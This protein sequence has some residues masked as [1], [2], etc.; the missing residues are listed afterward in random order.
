MNEDVLDYLF[1]WAQDTGYKY[2]REDFVK[3]I[4]SNDKV[5]NRAFEF[6]QSSK[7]PYKK[8]INS[9]ALL[10]GRTKPQG[11]Q[12]EPVAIEQTAKAEPTTTEPAKVEPQMTETVTAKVEE[13]VKESVVEEKPAIQVK[14]VEAPKEEVVKKEIPKEALNQNIIPITEKTEVKSVET[15]SDKLVVKSE[16]KEEVKE[17]PKPEGKPQMEVK[18]VTKEEPK[19]LK[20]KSLDEKVIEE[21][22]L[23]IKDVTKEESDKLKVKN[24]NTKTK[25]KDKNDYSIVGSGFG[26]SYEESK[27]HDQSHVERK[28][29][30]NKEVLKLATIR[31]ENN[32]SI[33]DFTVGYDKKNNK[34]Y[35]YDVLSSGKK[36]DQWEEVK[37]DKLISLL[38]NKFKDVTENK[39]LETKDFRKLASDPMPDAIIIDSYFKITPEKSIKPFGENGP[40]VYFDDEEN[41]Y[42]TKENGERKVIEKGSD[43]YNKII[44]K[45]IDLIS[46]QPIENSLDCPPGSSECS[47][48]ENNDKTQE[49]IMD[50][51]YFNLLGSWTQ[52]E[53]NLANHLD[54]IN[55]NYTE[56]EAIKKDGLALFVINR[57]TKSDYKID[58]PKIKQYRN[59]VFYIN[60]TPPSSKRFSIYYLD[61]SNKSYIYDNDTGAIMKQFDDKVDLPTGGMTNVW[62]TIPVDNPEYKKTRDLIELVKNKKEKG[63]KN[64]FVPLTTTPGIPEWSPIPN[65]NTSEQPQIQVKEVTEQ[66][67]AEV[68]VEPKMEVKGVKEEKSETPKYKRYSFKGSKPDKL[69]M[70]V[71][72]KDIIDIPDELRYKK[73]PEIEKKEGLYTYDDMKFDLENNPPA[74]LINSGEYNIDNNIKYEKLSPSEILEKDIFSGKNIKLERNVDLNFPDPPGIVLKKEKI[75]G[76]EVY[77]SYD[78]NNDKWYFYQEGSDKNNWTEVKS[79]AIK[80]MLNAKYK[81]DKHNTAI[82]KKSLYV[83]PKEDNISERQQSEIQRRKSALIYNVYIPYM[84]QNY[85]NLTEEQKNKFHKQLFE[86]SNV[87]AFASLP[88][89][90]EYPYSDMWNKVNEIYENEFKKANKVYN[91]K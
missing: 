49:F 28:N 19:N 84:I 41:E 16:K 21:K 62:G 55:K 47:N 32:N 77:P 71:N 60:E 56:E 20:V 17:Q 43:K 45:V 88:V 78:K 23:N 80:T 68:K 76:K 14:E 26:Y 46:K 87:K 18:D 33:K 89:S 67:K 30:K 52:K 90:S 22:N 72:T 61:D 8:D 3:L 2:S 24:N 58:D 38:N 13:P 86:D 37:S 63:S 34:W 74:F 48:K 6:A 7:K 42:F 1:K 69:P 64:T 51:D 29:F 70:N 40:T 27:K 83:K 5:L 44:N 54:E 85:D 91:K 10:V 81:T 59:K 53:G 66:P 31:K 65:K 9:F 35:S 79:G 50:K 39:Q 73:Q 82:D 4:Q 75:E 11:T 12:P 15:P 25:F 57:D 36:Y